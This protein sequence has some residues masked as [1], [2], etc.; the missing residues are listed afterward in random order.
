VKQLEV[1][2]RYNVKPFPTDNLKLEIARNVRE[3]LYPLKG[4]HY[5]PVGDTTGWYIYAGEEFSEALDYF[6]PLHIEQLPSWCPHLMP[7]MLLPSGWG[8]HRAWLRRRLVR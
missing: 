2:K 7:Y 4:L 6:V 8:C 3:G 1:C 5:L